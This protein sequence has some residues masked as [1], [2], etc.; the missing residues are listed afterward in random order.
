MLISGIGLLLLLAL[1]IFLYY[2]GVLAMVERNLS[3][4]SD[5]VVSLYPA[6][7]T[8]AKVVDVWIDVRDFDAAMFVTVTGALAGAFVGTPTAREADD[9]SGT[10]AANVAAADL[11]GAFVP[12]AANQTQKVGYRGTK[13]FIGVALAYVSGT[14]IAI[15]GTIERDYPHTAPKPNFTINP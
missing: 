1:F 9:S 14:S 5:P 4:N 10:N 3:Q 8:G 12:V 2:C 7:Q 15:A 11:Q 6:V 13:P